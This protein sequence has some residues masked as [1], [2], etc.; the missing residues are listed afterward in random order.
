MATEQ[1]L[2]WI[3]GAVAPPGQAP[4]KLSRNIESFEADFA[5]GFLFGEILS[6]YELVDMA[7]FSKK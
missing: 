3:G 2:N 6:H 5:N 7:Q 4:L 1:V